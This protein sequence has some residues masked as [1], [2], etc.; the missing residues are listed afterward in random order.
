V[1]LRNVSGA[2]RDVPDPTAV[3]SANDNADSSPSGLGTR[4]CWRLRVLGL[5]DVV[6][7]SDPEQIAWLNR[8]PDVVRPLDRDASLLHRM[9]HRRL[10]LD[11]GFDDG[12]LPVFLSRADGE[13][14]ARQADLA[15]SLQEAAGAPGWERDEIAGHIAGSAATDL[16][17]TVQQWCGRLFD[18]HYRSTPESYRAGRLLAEWPAA[19][20]WRALAARLSGRLARAKGVV[21]DAA[22]GDPH[23][24]HATSIGME[25]IARTV[26]EMQ[27]AAQL[28]ELENASANRVLARCLKAPVAVLRG[29][30]ARVEAPFLARPLTRRS[31]VVFLVARAYA[32]SGDMDVAFLAGGWSACPARHVV[33]EMLREAWYTA[34]QGAPRESGWAERVKPWG[35]VL[36]RAVSAFE[37]RA[38]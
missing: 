11:L 10:A 29:C 2:A 22:G 33:P 26:R 25:N 23:C 8:H 28:P 18:K 13:R 34:R 20:P 19:P 4:G 24:I 35:R 36:L 9:M 38:S 5:I 21:A 12:V 27:R 17:P 37:G 3:A 1:K 16:G 7:T 31:L 15:A 32:R 6:L 14:A 30:R